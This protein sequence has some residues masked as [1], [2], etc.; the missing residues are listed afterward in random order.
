M[1]ICNDN[2]AGCIE[3]SIGTYSK[4]YLEM[5]TLE[6]AYCVI[7]I[8][9]KILQLMRIF[10]PAFSKERQGFTLRFRHWKIIFYKGL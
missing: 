9:N 8:C 3:T 5:L 1:T 4:V 10:I 6:Q 2:D 7:L